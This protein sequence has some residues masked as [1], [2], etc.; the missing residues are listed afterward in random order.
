MTEEELDEV[1]T[2]ILWMRG[3]LLS[4]DPTITDFNIGMSCG[5]STG[6]AILHAHVQLTTRRDGDTQNLRGGVRGMILEKVNY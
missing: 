4:R 6:Q 5:Q 1:E 3:R 2:F